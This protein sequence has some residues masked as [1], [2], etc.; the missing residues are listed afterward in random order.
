MGSR[1]VTTESGRWSRLREV[2]AD[3]GAKPGLLRL[4]KGDESRNGAWL[5][6]SAFL[7]SAERAV[8]VCDDESIAADAREFLGLLMMHVA[9]QTRVSKCVEAIVELAAGGWLAEAG[10]LCPDPSQTKPANNP[11]DLR[12]CVAG[13]HI[14]FEVKA[15]YDAFEKELMEGSFRGDPEGLLTILEKLFGKDVRSA[16]VWPRK[17]PSREDW[18]K[19][20]ARVR[21]KF[22]KEIQD[23]GEIPPGGKRVFKYSRPLCGLVLELHV[24]VEAHPT[25]TIRLADLGWQDIAKRVRGHATHKAERAECPFILLYV[26][27]PPQPNSING[28]CLARIKDDFLGDPG[29]LPPSLAGVVCLRLSPMGDA[30]GDAVGFLTR[31]APFSW[32]SLQNALR[33][34]P[35]PPPGPALI[36]SLHLL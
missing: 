20:R 27:Q 4:L 28:P 7:D 26:S 11:I 23:S 10:V 33:V 31:A 30:A 5:Y 9:E 36:G 24:S 17:R 29:L 6:S 18:E 35:P 32:E 8:R 14:G 19:D 25:S 16:V 12:A 34:Q 3:L 15:D 1:R 22:A 2:A 13:R 21:A